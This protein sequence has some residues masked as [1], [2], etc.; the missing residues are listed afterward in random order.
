MAFEL[1]TETGTR[2][3]EY[4]SITENKTFG[5]PRPFIAKQGITKDHKCVILYDSVKQAIALHFS[6]NDPKFGLAVRIPNDTQGGMIVARTFFDLKDIDVAKYAHRYEFQKVSL[7]NLGQEKDGD[8][9]LIKLTP[10]KDHTTESN[11]VVEEADPKGINWDD[12]PF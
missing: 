8:A 10:R 11:P 1:F 2:T 9:Y 12:L 5:L 3:K 6:T 4:I 7:K